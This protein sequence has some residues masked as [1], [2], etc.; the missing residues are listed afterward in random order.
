MAI[1]CEAAPINEAHDS[2][3]LFIRS[4]LS[5]L[6]RRVVLLNVEGSVMANTDRRGALT[7]FFTMRLR[8]RHRPYLLEYPDLWS[9]ALAALNVE[10][11]VRIHAFVLLPDH[12]HIIWTVVGARGHVRRCNFLARYFT[13]ALAARTGA[14]DRLQRAEFCVFRAFYPTTSIH[15]LKELK[16]CRLRIERDPVRHG[17]VQEPAGWSYSSDQWRARGAL[18]SGI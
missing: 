18:S 8:S 10:H 16:R 2:S 9:E 13:E 7:Y 11:P 5:R 3:F 14:R 17:L 15:T 1:T 6:L 12:A 4:S